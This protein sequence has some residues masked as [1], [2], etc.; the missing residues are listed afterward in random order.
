MA[1]PEHVWVR[2]ME[3]FA[4]KTNHWNEKQ[5][6]LDTHKRT[7]T[8]PNKDKSVSH[9]H[10]TDVVKTQDPLYGRPIKPDAPRK[11][12]RVIDTN[13]VTRPDLNPIYGCNPKTFQYTKDALLSLMILLPELNA[14]ICSYV[15]CKHTRVCVVNSIPYIFEHG[16][17]A[18]DRSL[19]ITHNPAK[20]GQTIIGSP[21]Y[22]FERY[23]NGTGYVDRCFHGRFENNA[24]LDACPQFDGK[25][26]MSVRDQTKGSLSIIVTSN[27][28]NVM[29][30]DDEYG[31]ILANPHVLPTAET[32]HDT[33]SRM[34]LLV[35]NK[36]TYDSLPTHSELGSYLRRFSI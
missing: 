33:S 26:P 20:C 30:P 12:Q 15:E 18:Y 9:H 28:P 25:H 8:F 17:P 29:M 13:V 27:H 11:L 6:D 14:I 3:T 2:M 16:G 36:R 1:I 22:F 24:H 4:Q 34:D 5:W 31:F 7:E 35:A 21:T 32:L 23:D 19:S 10:P